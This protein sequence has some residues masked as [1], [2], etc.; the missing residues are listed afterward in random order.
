MAMQWN[1]GL[2]LRYR[3]IILHSPSKLR[4]LVK[5]DV[6]VHPV[7]WAGADVQNYRRQQN[8]MWSLQQVDDGLGVLQSDRP[9][10]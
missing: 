7:K 1:P 5:S 2:S 8:F 9:L 10:K 3:A 4:Q 6:S